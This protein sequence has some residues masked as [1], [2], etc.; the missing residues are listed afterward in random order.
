MITP[1]TQGL[2]QNGKRHLPDL[3]Q[4]QSDAVPSPK[5]KRIGTWDAFRNANT[6]RTVGGRSTPELREVER[7]MDAIIAFRVGIHQYSV[8]RLA[9]CL[10]EPG[11]T[12]L[13]AGR[14]MGRVVDRV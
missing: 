2:E 13:E 9:E 12:R 14:A 3:G 5:A 4:S 1:E 7:L 8:R 11:S 10:A 6:Y